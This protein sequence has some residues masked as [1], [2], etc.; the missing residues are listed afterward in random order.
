MIRGQTPCIQHH[1]HLIIV[2][3]S[4]TQRRRRC[5][6]SYPF[7]SAADTPYHKMEWRRLW[8]SLERMTDSHR[9]QEDLIGFPDKTNQNTLKLSNLPP[10]LIILIISMLS[11]N[12]AGCLSLCNRAMS[13]ILSPNI[14]RCLNLQNPEMRASF[15]CDLSKDLPQY[16]VCYRCVQ[17]HASN[18]VQ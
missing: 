4:N 17:L 6:P 3:T 5:A 18:A 7:Q 13:Q 9:Q 15:L 11:T 12:S 14:W 10:E 16:F 1:L 2:I 8:H